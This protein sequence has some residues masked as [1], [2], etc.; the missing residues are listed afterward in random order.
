MFLL[1]ISANH[2]T[3]GTQKTSEDFYAENPDADIEQWNT[4]IPAVLLKNHSRFVSQE[5]DGHTDSS[6][7]GL[8]EAASEDP[9]EAEKQEVD[10]QTEKERF[11]KWLRGNRPSH[12]Y[13]YMC[14]QLL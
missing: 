9:D 2:L 7:G 14:T 1:T 6:A 5:S 3:T 12:I 10:V 13:R 4:F 8:P 11:E